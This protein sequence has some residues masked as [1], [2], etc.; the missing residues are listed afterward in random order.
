MDDHDGFHDDEYPPWEYLI[1]AADALDERAPGTLRG[2]GPLIPVETGRRPRVSL[3][4]MTA[5][6][7][8]GTLALVVLAFLGR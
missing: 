7:M 8:L 2:L 3:R 5:V 6:I 4:A 1:E